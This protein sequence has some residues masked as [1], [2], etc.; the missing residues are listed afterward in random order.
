[1]GWGR[2]GE[3]KIRYSLELR[4]QPPMHVVE[5]HVVHDPDGGQVNAEVEMPP[6]RRKTELCA[7]SNFGI[8]R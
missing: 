3:R 6:L 7:F 8:T 4:Q 2:G 1:M 5:V